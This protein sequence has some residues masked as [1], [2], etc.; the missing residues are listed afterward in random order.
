VQTNYTISIARTKNVVTNGRS[1][2]NQGQCAK[3]A[4]IKRAAEMKNNNQ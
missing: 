4:T 3:Q 2:V 1:N